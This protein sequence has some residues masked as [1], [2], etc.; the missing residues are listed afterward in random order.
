MRKALSYA[1]DYDYIITE[2][3][4]DLALR[5]RSPIPKGILYS[6]TE[7]FDVPVLDLTIARQALI[8]SGLYG[9]LPAV[10]DDAAWEA[11]AVNNPIATY[12]Y[13]YNI[14]NSMREDM[15]LVCQDNFAK[16][17]VKVTDAGMTW[18]E[19]IYRGYEIGGLTRNMVQLGFIGW[20]PDYNDPANFINPLFTNKVIAS[21]F[22]QV[23]DAEVQQWMEQGLSETDPVAREQLYYNIQEKL[24]EEIYPWCWCYVG[25][26]YDAFDASLRGLQGNAMNNMRF[27]FCYFV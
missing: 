17:G 20:G 4:E 26:N 24:I 10:G 15:L 1:L 19:F 3:M 8:D 27:K 16:I 11:L 12:N 7:D 22:A 6:N 23:D 9:S 14:G 13:T 25:L 18:G 2:L 5:M 21:N